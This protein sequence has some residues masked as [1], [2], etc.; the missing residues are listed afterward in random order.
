MKDRDRLYKNFPET[1]GVYLMKNAR[2]NMLYIGKAANL[3]RRVASYFIRPHDSRIERLAKAVKKIDIRQTDSVLEALILESKLIKKHQPIFNVREKDDRSFLYVEITKERFP[4]VLLARG[5]SVA[6]AGTAVRA[7]ANAVFG[8][9]TSASSLREALD[10]LRRIFSWNTHSPEEIGKTRRECLDFQIGLCPGAC[11][12][13]IDQKIYLKNIAKLKLF[14]AGKKKRIIVALEKEM[15][16]ASKKLEFESAE[17]IRRQIFALRHIR[18]V[19][20]LTH[21]DLEP[22]IAGSKAKKIRIEGYDISNISGT[23]AVGSMVVFSS[24][25]GNFRPDTSEYRKFRIRSGNT[26]D[27]AGMITE[28]LERRFKKNPLDG[29]CL[30]DRH[31]WPLPNCILIDGGS[32]QVNAAWKVLVRR[33]LKIPIVGIAKGPER[34]NN[35]V[36]GTIPEGI[37]KETLIRV[38]DE[39]H[40]FAM[41]YHRKVRSMHF[42]KN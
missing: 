17:K 18:D 20:F 4:R 24:E 19:A 40:R 30:P 3:K 32:G 5:R 14:L 1:P 6:G 11:V 2:G 10:I 13:A 37:T 15:A 12:G 38:R 35:F 39:A 31:R 34:K 22:R 9:F 16:A 42:L 29:A 21:D 41:A 8:P 26:P 25:G 27:D 23:S 33:R 7:K 28:I 36:M